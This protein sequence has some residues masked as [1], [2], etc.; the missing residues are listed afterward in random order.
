MGRIIASSEE[1]LGPAEQVVQPA[2]LSCEVYSLS[3]EKYVS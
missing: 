3:I 2:A 1:K